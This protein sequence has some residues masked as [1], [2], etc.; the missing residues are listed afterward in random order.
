MTIIFIPIWDGSNGCASFIVGDDSDGRGIV[1]DPLATFGADSYI[2]NAAEVGLKI[3]GVIETHVHADHHSVAREL[4]QKADLLVS[5]GYR[6]PLA[7]AFNPLHEGEQFDLGGVKVKVLE[8]PG[9]TPESISLVVTDETRSPDPWLV[10]SGDSLFVGDV[11]RPDLVDPTPELTDQAALDQFHSVHDKI[12]ALPDTTELYPA[13]YGASAC[14]GLFLSPKPIS[15][16]G[17][18]RRWNRFAQI[19]EPQQFVQE[20][21]SLLKPPPPDAAAIRRQNLGE[22]STNQEGGN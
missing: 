13:H 18:E 20:L 6:A 3:V 12:L 19:T 9:H 5:M 1:V 2:L 7:E 22:L 11:G 8:T 10:L 21:L 15:T 14:G 4:A 16:I 17:Y